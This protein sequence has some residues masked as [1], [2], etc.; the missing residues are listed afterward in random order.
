MNDP[1]LW[2]FQLSADDLGGFGGL[3]SAAV[4]ELR[5]EYASTPISVFSLRPPVP[6]D[7]DKLDVRMRLLND[8]LA[9]SLL[10]GG[11]Q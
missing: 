6:K 9:T 7:E 4:E 11:R 1:G 10:A 8:A 2:G 3:A 5:D